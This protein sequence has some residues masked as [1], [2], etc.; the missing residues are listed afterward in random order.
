ML[1]QNIIGQNELKTQ[2]IRSIRAGRVSHCQLFLGSEGTGALPLALAYAQY[3]NCLNPNPTDSCGVCGSCIK[4]QKLIHPDL[5]FSFPVVAKKSGEKP[6]SSHFLKEFRHSLLVNP[7]LTYHDFMMAIEAENKQG[8]ISVAECH[9][10]LERLNLAIFEAK[11]KVMLIWLPEYL[12]EAGNVLLKILEEP[13]ANTLFLLVTHHSEQLL[14]TVVSR[15]QLTRVPLLTHDDIAHHLIHKKGVAAADAQT[16]GVL[17]CGNYREALRQIE[18]SSLENETVF[19][20]WMRVLFSR[21]GQKI[22]HFTEKMAA[23]GREQQKNYLVYSLHIIRQCMLKHLDQER[24]IQSNGTELAFID[25][26]YPYLP[27]QNLETIS[28]H[29]NESIFQVERNGNSKLVFHCLSMRVESLLK[30]Q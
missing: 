3:L 16:I 11:Y 10:I 18:L 2:L 21:D 28:N 25:R 13:P 27:L 9:H 15:C 14:S 5:H 12:K 8:N 26:F 4:Y 6:L 19:A 20:H 1:F 29:L 22:V 30:R 17:S 7:Y 23:L 24:L